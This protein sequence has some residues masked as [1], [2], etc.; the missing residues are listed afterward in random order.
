MSNAIKFYIDASINCYAFEDIDL[1]QGKLK[2]S[3]IE[4]SNKTV[5]LDKSYYMTKENFKSE[6]KDCLQGEINSDNLSFSYEPMEPAKEFRVSFDGNLEFKSE[7][8]LNDISELKAD[9]ISISFISTEGIQDDLS[10]SS[11]DFCDVKKL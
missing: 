6:G 9:L 10:T 7:D 1:N 8:D 2:I 11:V 4:F 5:L 3:Y